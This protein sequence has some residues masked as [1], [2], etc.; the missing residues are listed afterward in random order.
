MSYQ[1]QTRFLYHLAPQVRVAQDG[2]P[3][4]SK[5]QAACLQA[6]YEHSPFEEREPYQSEHLG[7]RGVSAVRRVRDGHELPTHD[8]PLA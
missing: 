8:S 6:G 2:F 1:F 7:N 5:R 4:L 3:P